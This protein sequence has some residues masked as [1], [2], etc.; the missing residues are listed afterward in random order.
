MKQRQTPYAKFTSLFSELT[1]AISHG[2]SI[3]FIV[4]YGLNHYLV[5]DSFR[6]LLALN[7]K[8]DIDCSILDARDVTEVE[9]ASLWEQQTLFTPKTFYSFQSCEKA[10]RILDFLTK[11]LPQHGTSHTFCFSFGNKTIP[12]RIKNSLDKYNGFVI[13][14]SEPYQSELLEYIKQQ[15]IKSKLPLNMDAC[16]LIA[17]SQG[18]NFFKINNE[19]QKLALTL[20]SS[21]QRSSSIKRNDIAHLIHSQRLD[22]LFE[23]ENLLLQRSYSLGLQHVQQLLKSGEPLLTIISV[24]ANHCRKTLKIKSLPTSSTPQD[25][26]NSTNIPIWM[27]GKYQ[28]YAR[29]IPQQTLRQVLERCHVADVNFKST[30]ISPDILA[31]DTIMGFVN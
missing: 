21:N 23:I 26:A 28:A 19:I 14:C 18:S 16:R 22:S 29:K 4:L 20:A 27:V 1:K 25:I 15:S 5:Y 8:L 2:E 12:A 10:P 9:F 3:P 31:S 13:Q 11:F 24:I 6:S 17:E 7:K 30:R